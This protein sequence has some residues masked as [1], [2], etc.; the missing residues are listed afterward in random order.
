MLVGQIIQPQVGPN[1]FRNID[2]HVAAA[3]PRGEQADL[4]IALRMNRALKESQPRMPTTGVW[5]E[6]DRSVGIGEPC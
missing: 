2:H 1:C 3:L 4:G 6:S 5:Q